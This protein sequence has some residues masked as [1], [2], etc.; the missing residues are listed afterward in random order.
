MPK[1]ENPKLRCS[2]PFKYEVVTVE[3]DTLE[4]GP[5]GSSTV[6]SELDKLIESVIRH[7]D[8]LGKV[9][10]DLTELTDVFALPPHEVERNRRDSGGPID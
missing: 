3:E 9:T 5:R 4:V 1:T 8:R 10:Y 6:G 2:V 7:G